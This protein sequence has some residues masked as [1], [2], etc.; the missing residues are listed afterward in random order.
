MTLKDYQMG[1]WIR[2]Q[3]FAWANKG[4]LPADLNKLARLAGAED[5]ALFKSEVDAVLFEYELVDGQQ[6]NAKMA[7]H[8]ADAQELTKKRVKAGKARAEKARALSTP[9]E[10]E[11]AAA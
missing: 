9:I 8:W 11:E 1:W 10:E 2:L 7:A 5:T 6:V 4:V 3:A